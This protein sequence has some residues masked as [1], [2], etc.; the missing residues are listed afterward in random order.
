MGVVAGGQTTTAA[1]G[2]IN[3][4]AESQVPTLGYT[5][6]YAVGNVLLT[7]WGAVVVALLA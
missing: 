4:G 7:I 5:V 2:A 1:I 3:E 6:P